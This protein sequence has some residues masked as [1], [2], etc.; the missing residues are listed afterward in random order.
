MHIPVPAFGKNKTSLFAMLKIL[1]IHNL[2][3]LQVTKTAFLGLA[4]CLGLIVL[5]FG[6]LSLATAVPMA[7]RA[8]LS[9]AGPV[10]TTVVD[11][12]FFKCTNTAHGFNG[13]HNSVSN[14]ADDELR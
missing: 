1:K 14:S 3:S 7:A 11:G 6:L 5:A 12:K 13:G 9:G 4:S 10:V 2:K 8:A